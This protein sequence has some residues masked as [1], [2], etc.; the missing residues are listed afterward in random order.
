MRLLTTQLTVRLICGD[1]GQYKNLLSH[2]VCKGLI[3]WTIEVAHE[4]L[5]GVLRSI[6]QLTC[7]LSSLL[8]RS[9]YCSIIINQHLR[10]VYI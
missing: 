8:S 2:S 6:G 10:A 9:F 3:E 5:F 7:L 1:E 4:G